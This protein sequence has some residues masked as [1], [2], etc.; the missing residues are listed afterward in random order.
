MCP[1]LGK[2]M[3]QGKGQSHDYSPTL[4]RLNSQWGYVP[5]NI[6]VISLAANRAKG[7][8]RAE[9][10]ERIAQWMRAQGLA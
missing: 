3:S 6:A 1:A 9:E 2:K 10:L 8:M 7:A 5:G 4:D